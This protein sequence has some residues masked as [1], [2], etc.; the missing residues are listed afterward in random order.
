MLVVV[1]EQ[2]PCL[3]QGR[4][5]LFLETEVAGDNL[6]HVADVVTVLLLVELEFVLEQVV[7]LLEDRDPSQSVRKRLK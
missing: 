5:L 7:L 3:L 2:E 6:A 4:I 1:L